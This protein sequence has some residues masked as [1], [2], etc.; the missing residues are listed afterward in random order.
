MY[1]EK[2]ARKGH[3]KVIYKGTF[4]SKQSLAELRSSQN[5]TQNVSRILEKKTDGHQR[6]K[7]RKTAINVPLQ[8]NNMSKILLMFIKKQ[9]TAEL[10]KNVVHKCS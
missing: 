9:M 8:L 4:V 1:G 7:I 10:F 2:M 5:L 6:Q 3:T